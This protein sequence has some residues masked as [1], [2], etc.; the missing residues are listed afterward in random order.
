MRHAHPMGCPTHVHIKC[1]YS[2]QHVRYIL[3]EICECSTASR[4]TI[5]PRRCLS[6]RPIAQTLFLICARPSF[7][8]SRYNPSTQMFRT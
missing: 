2:T 7:D 5:P 6:I 8:E 1:W 3:A 4:S